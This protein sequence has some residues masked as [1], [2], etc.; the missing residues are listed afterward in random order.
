[1]TLF[2]DLPAPV[3]L[4]DIAAMTGAELEA[5]D[6]DAEIVALASL[7]WAR[8]GDLCF[9]DGPRY[10]PLLPHCRATACFMRRAQALARPSGVAALIVDD[11]QD[12]M[13]RCAAELF[14]AALR[15]AA[16]FGESGVSPSAIV[17][18]TA[19]LE[20]KVTL[21]PGAVIGPGAQIGAR[22]IIGANAVIG[23]NVC[24][25]RDCSIGSNASLSH[26][27]IGD[28]V[29]VHPGARLGQD[30]FGFALSGAGARKIA[31][32]GRVIVQDEVEIGANTTIDRGSFGD[33]IIGE[34]A[35]IDNLVQIGH[36][37]VVGRGCLIAAQ[38]GIA[39]STTIGEFVLFGGQSGVAGHLRVGDRAAIAAQSG[40]MRDV[41]PKARIGGAPA[42]PLRRFLRAH[43]LLG[44]LA[45]RREEPSKE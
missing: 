30:G 35:K 22:T 31:Q 32:L 28:R 10:H 26:A 18:P 11:P 16:I 3:A 14:P 21:D 8:P 13:A 42:R 15:P 4:R 25:G 5:R 41:E 7:E 19:R 2:F 27:L 38:S 45:A 9:L 40:V 44:K 1:M 36:N 20:E 29:I 34:G 12:A 17:H 43:A 6:A 33:T 37:V 24:V 39:G 23:Q